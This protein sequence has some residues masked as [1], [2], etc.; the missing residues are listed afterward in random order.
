MTP[1]PTV[2]PRPAR[3]RKWRAISISLAVLGFA[4]FVAANAHLVYVAFVSQP[5]CVAHERAG[6]SGGGPF[7]AAKSSC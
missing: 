3:R 7:G 5:D 1:L 6:A 4:V 2:D